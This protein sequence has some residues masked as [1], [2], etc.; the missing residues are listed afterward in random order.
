MAGLQS[1][2][3][4]FSPPVLNKLCPGWWWVW[5]VRGEARGGRAEVAQYK[6]YQVWLWQWAVVSLQRSGDSQTELLFLLQLF[7]LTATIQPSTIQY[8]GHNYQMFLLNKERK[9]VH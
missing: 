7:L 8:S 2:I 6:E 4:V 1:I 9:K 5:W 3:S